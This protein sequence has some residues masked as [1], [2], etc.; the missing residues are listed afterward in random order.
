MIDDYSRGAAPGRSELTTPVLRPGPRPPARTADDVEDQ[1]DG[2]EA[3]F[4]DGRARC[5]W[6]GEYTWVGEYTFYTFPESDLNLNLNLTCH[7]L[8]PYYRYESPQTWWSPHLPRQRFSR[9]RAISRR[10]CAEWSVKSTSL[11][12]S[13]CRH[14][15]ARPQ[16]PSLAISS[17][18]LLSWGFFLSFPLT[19]T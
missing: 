18:R 8:E 11:R 1:D 4:K 13:T 17:S 14:A 9:K 2:D 19:R 3:R 10:N 6:Q 7:D 5:S 12:A 15:P 16:P